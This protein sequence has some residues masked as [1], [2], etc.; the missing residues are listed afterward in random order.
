VLKYSED[1]Q[2]ARAAGFGGLADGDE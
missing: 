2:T 1:L